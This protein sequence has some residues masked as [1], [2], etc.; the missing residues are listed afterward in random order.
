MTAITISTGLPRSGTNLFTKAMSAHQNISWACGPNIELFR[1]FRDAVVQEINDEGVARYCPQHS[2]FS[3]YFGSAPGTKLLGKVLHADF[4]A[5]ISNS[6]LIAQLSRAINRP[7]HDSPDLIPHL[8]E[9]SGFCFTDLVNRQVQI[10]ASARPKPQLRTIGIHESWIIETLPAFLTSFHESKAVVV[11]RDPRATIASMLAAAQK[12]PASKAPLLGYI[13]HFRKQFAITAWMQH[14]HEFQSRVLVVRHEDLLV[15][16]KTTLQQVCV[17]LG[18]EFQEQMLE[19]D[20]YWD[21]GRNEYWRGNSAYGNVA[22]G[23]DPARTTR[24][25]DSLSEHSAECIEAL[26]AYELTALGYQVAQPRNL[27]YEAFATAVGPLQ[28]VNQVRWTNSYRSQKEEYALELARIDSIK[29]GQH[30]LRTSGEFHSLLI[31][32]EA[33]TLS[34]SLRVGTS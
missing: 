23:F 26:C 17:F 6:R 7:D 31:S 14:R 16:P 13:R 22:L 34:R 25:Q 29:S 19:T 24:W 21:Y 28:E 9:L 2:P 15:D 27:S 33:Y 4:S 20:K 18:H 8:R 1:D 32:P 12:D 30:N 3:D 5:S 10:V 11:F